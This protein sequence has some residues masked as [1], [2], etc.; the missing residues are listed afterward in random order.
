MSKHVLF[1][2]SNQLLCGLPG[3]CLHMDCGGRP[4]GS[5]ELDLPEVN[6]PNLE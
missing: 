1:I 3:L 6:H 4:S 5:A 2:C